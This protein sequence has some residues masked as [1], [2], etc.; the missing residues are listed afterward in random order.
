MSE[1]QRGPY[2]P[3]R[4][5]PPR[6][7]PLQ[8]DARG[9][10]DARPMPMTLIASGVVLVV[11]IGGVIMAYAGGF[12]RKD[13]PTRI[14]GDR[15]LVMKTAPAAGTEATSAGAEQTVAANRADGAPPSFTA[16][17]EQPVPR[18]KP[19]LQLRS[20]TL[21]PVRIASTDDEASPSSSG[22]R[23]SV[24]TSTLLPTT[25]ATT[26]AKP[27][28]SSAA[29][30]TKTTAAAHAAP[31][32]GSVATGAAGVQIGAFS[33]H[34]LADKGFADV[35]KLMPTAGHGKRIEAVERGGSTLYRTTVTGFADRDA[36]KSF[37]EAL[38]AKGHACIV[39]G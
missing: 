30:T 5:G 9:A 16:A 1:E 26:K 3:P 32:T 4:P 39:K 21:P 24:P 35:G 8:F 28:T 13:E 27:A 25:H 6:E 20:Q 7:A 19:Q 15:V 22:A 37:C 38:T 10:R 14:V 33:S 2:T 23:P 36:A 31:E 12:H 34:D 11:L 17:P 18:P 29:V